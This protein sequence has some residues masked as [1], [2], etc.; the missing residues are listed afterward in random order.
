MILKRHIIRNNYIYKD[1][2]TIRKLINECQLYSQS[3]K[4]HKNLTVMLK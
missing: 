4:T 1:I 3:I 2:Y